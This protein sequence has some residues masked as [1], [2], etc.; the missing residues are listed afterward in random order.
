M[1]NFQDFCNL[2]W[3]IISNFDQ[4]GLYEYC[5]SVRC[6]HTHSHSHF[7]PFLYIPSWKCKLIM[8]INCIANTNFRVCWNLLSFTDFSLFNDNLFLLHTI[9]HTF[10][11]N[12]LYPSLLKFGTKHFTIQNWIELKK[13][14]LEVWFTQL[15]CAI[16]VKALINPQVQCFIKVDQ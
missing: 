13:I 16:W 10:P 4:G 3:F 14:Y 7:L 15:K 11:G 5:P 12:L 8:Q 1:Q 2:L 9:F 6:C